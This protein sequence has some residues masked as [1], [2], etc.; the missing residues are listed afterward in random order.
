M[1]KE[2]ARAKFIWSKIMDRCY[3]PTDGDYRWYGAVGVVVCEE[4]KDFSVFKQWYF[5]NYYSIEGQQVSI[6]KDIVG[7]EQKIYSPKTCIIIPLK[8]H[9]SMNKKKLSKSRGVQQRGK[10]YEVKVRNTFTGENEYKGR[11]DE[12][13]VA[14]KVYLECKNAIFQGL[15][16]SYAGLMP[17]RVFQI[18]KYHKIK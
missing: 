18:L 7:G 14:K 9:N 6:D 5:E 15:V 11:Y 10:M 4:W 16:D 1:N 2:T 13:E 8:L 12:I 17:T 3:K